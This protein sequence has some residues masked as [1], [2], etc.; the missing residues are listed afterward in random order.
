LRIMPP[1]Q[2]A[3]ASTE[4]SFGLHGGIPILVGP[5]RK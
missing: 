4:P 2:E 5:M 3:T 1:L